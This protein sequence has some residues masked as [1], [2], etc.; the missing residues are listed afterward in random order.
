MP[1]APPRLAGVILAAGGS[2]RMGSVKQLLDIGGRTLLAH[3]VDVVLDSGTWPVCVV[4]GAHAGEIRTHLTHA[5]IL[6]VDNADW[7]TGMASSI[8]AGISAVLEASPGLEA[9]LVTPG[10]LPA[11]AA[12]DIVALAGLHR[13]SGLVSAARYAGRL[14]APAVFGR[15]H[16]GDLM[17]LKGDQG[18][19]RI[20]NAD[21]SKVA[22]ADL[23]SL[24]FDLDTPS[25]YAAW[26]GR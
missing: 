25:D 1:E 20:L 24:A 19:R 2:S 12:G 10:D 23:P 7:R 4:L 17:N 11:L 8:R 13:S 3:T 6:V 9:L 18:A 14:G 5:G 22:A 21:P 16:L 26:K 15:S